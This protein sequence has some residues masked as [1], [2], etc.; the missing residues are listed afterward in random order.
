MT[1]T[2][3]FHENIRIYTF[4]CSSLELSRTCIVEQVDTVVDDVQM[5]RRGI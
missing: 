3:T 1:V 4:D 2:H 5:K